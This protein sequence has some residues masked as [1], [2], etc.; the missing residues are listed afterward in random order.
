EGKFLRWGSY[1]LM[2]LLLSLVPNFYGSWQIGRHLG[3]YWN[4]TDIVRVLS[5]PLSIISSF[6]GGPFPS[7]YAP[8]A[9]RI[10]RSSDVGMVASLPLLLVSALIAG[11]ATW[12]SVLLVA[13]ALR[14]DITEPVL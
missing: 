9:Y 14:K 13:K 1:I 12:C 3:N 4:E 2:L 5:H 6:A 8:N 7:P 11:A 10:L